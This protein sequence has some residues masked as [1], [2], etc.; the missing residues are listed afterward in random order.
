MDHSSPP[1]TTTA[2]RDI[3]LCIISTATSSE[4]RITPSWTIFQL[5]AKL[6]S[7]TGIPPSAQR[8]ALRLPG[9]EGETLIEADDEHAVAIG[10]WPLVPYAEI[11]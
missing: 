9:Q 2:P 8:L 6:E 5:K 3:P 11:K 10:R 1:L 7:I 4:R